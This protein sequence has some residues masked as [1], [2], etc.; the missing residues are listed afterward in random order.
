MVA[1]GETVG[2]AEWIIDVLNFLDCFICRVFAGNFLSCH[3]KDWQFQFVIKTRY[4]LRVTFEI[5][6]NYF[7]IIIVLYFHQPKTLKKC[8]EHMTILLFLLLFC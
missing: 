8:G 6:K 3:S 7:C 2:L 1:T 4:D 5:Y